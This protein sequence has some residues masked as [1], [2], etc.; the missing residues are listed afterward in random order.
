MAGN[1]FEAIRDML[2]P[3]PVSDVQTYA[4]QDYPKAQE[5]PMSGPMMPPPQLPAPMSFGMS[6]PA[7]ATPNIP[8]APSQENAP[9][10]LDKFNAMMS[11][12]ERN[13][14]IVMALNTLRSTP[15]ASL[16][17][18]MQ[19][20]ID[21]AQAMSLTK[22]TAQTAITQLQGIGT[23]A[24]LSAAKLIEANPTMVKEI[25]QKYYGESIKPTTKTT[26]LSGK[27]LNQMAADNG[28]AAVYDPDKMYN[29]ET[30]AEGTKVT[31]IGG[32][33]TINLTDSPEAAGQ[34]KEQEERV[35][36]GVQYLGDIKK[37]GSTAADLRRNVNVLRQIGEAED[38]NAIPG[39]I[40]GILPSGVSSVVDAYTGIVNTVAKA[41]RQA[42]TG[43]QSDKDFDV[44]VQ[45]SGPIASDVQARR[46]MQQALL[47]KAAIDEARADVSTRYFSGKLGLADAMEQIAELDKQSIF[48]PEMKTYI[49]NLTG[50]VDVSGIERPAN[51]TES[52][53]SMMPDRDKALFRGQ[54]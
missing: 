3:K 35:K 5:V 21:T 14:Q 1:L 17:A 19:K 43:T 13:A 25:L 31:S 10:L 36:A 37:I 28:T 48:T 49:E 6:Q 34:K 41:Q 51:I 23:P 4:L 50:K 24:A 45:Q 7:Q 38:F 32:G 47:Q 30:G 18:A 11:D 52:V 16:A 40:R 26:Q 46:I 53:W 29:L 44:L 33:Q 9:S 8:V 42:G 22:K 39:V 20:R 15:D 12:P 2:M 54:Q 27:V